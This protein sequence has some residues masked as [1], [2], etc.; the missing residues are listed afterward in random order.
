[1]SQLAK[2]WCVGLAIGLPLLGVVV[3]ILALALGLGEW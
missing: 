2:R 3:S 1:M